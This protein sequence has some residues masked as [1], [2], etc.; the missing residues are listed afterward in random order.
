M[1]RSPFFICYLLPCFGPGRMGQVNQQNGQRDQ[2]CPNGP[3]LEIPAQDGGQDAAHHK[4][5]N[6]FQMAVHPSSVLYVSA[7]DGFAAGNARLPQMVGTKGGSHGDPLGGPEGVVLHGAHKID[8]NLGDLI[9]CV[10]RNQAQYHH[11]PYFNADQRCFPMDGKLP[12]GRSE[13]HLR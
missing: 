2:G 1:E 3:P 8:D 6:H 7:P 11:D 12:S 4:Y 5:C 13:C 9:G 10:L